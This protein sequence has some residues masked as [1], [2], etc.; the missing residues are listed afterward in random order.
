MKSLSATWTDSKIL[1]VEYINLSDPQDDEVQIKVGSA[2][3]CG[4]DLH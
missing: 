2:G 4:S 3:I 1:N